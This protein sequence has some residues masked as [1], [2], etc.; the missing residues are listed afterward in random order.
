M[1]DTATNITGGCLCGPLRC[2][3]DGAPLR[4][5]GRTRQFV[6]KSARGGN[7]VRNA[8]AVRR[9]QVFGGLPG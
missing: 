4:F 7:A 3:A 5:S 2:E 6:T 1:D 8:S 9:R